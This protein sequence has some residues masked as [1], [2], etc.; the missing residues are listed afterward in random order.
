MGSLLLGAALLLDFNEDVKNLVHA[1]A[2]VSRDRGGGGGIEAAGETDVA[3][4]G[5]NVVSGVESE[6]ARPSI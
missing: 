4:G 2:A 6:P 5:A 1:A 3:V